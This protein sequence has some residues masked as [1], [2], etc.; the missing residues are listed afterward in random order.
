[1]TN[2][3]GFLCM[4]EIDMF[5]HSDVTPGLFPGADQKVTSLLQSKLLPHVVREALLEGTRH[6]AE[7]AAKRGMVDGL[8]SP[9]QL[10]P[11]SLA[12]A[13]RLAQN[14]VPK[15][16]ATMA[17]LKHELVRATVRIL[18]QPSVHSSL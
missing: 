3:K 4:N 5:R 15:N 6:T 2:G 7:E 13:Q 1:M 14:A 16:R 11:T 9:E 8:A 10:V 18:R 17:L 12:L